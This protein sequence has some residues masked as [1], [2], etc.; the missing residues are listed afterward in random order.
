[1]VLG[2]DL[3][4]ILLVRRTNDYLTIMQKFQE[5]QKNCGV[6][7]KTKAE[8]DQTVDER[9]EQL[10]LNGDTSSPEYKLLLAIHQR[11]LGSL[12]LAV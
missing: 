6:K 11:R 2:L 7:L 5:A 4:S 12:P 8:S 1:M 9:L 3:A 10:R